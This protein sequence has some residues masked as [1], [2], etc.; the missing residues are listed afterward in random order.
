[1]RQERN[2]SELSEITVVEP[3]PINALA[4][5]MVTEPI[6]HESEVSLNRIR[7]EGDVMVSLGSNDS[8]SSFSSDGSGS[9]QK[10]RTNTTTS[11]ERI[12]LQPK[13]EFFSTLIEIYKKKEQLSRKDSS[14]DKKI[15]NHLYYFL[16][17]AIKKRDLDVE[18]DRRHSKQQMYNSGEL[19]Y[20]SI[21]LNSMKIRTLDEIKV[22]KDSFDAHY[23]N[24]NY[25]I[26]S[27]MEPYN[28]DFFSIGND[29]RKFFINLITEISKKILKRIDKIEKNSC[30]GARNISRIGKN[31]IDG[32]VS[33]L[34]YLF[35]NLTSFE[36]KQLTADSSSLARQ[37]NF[38]P[39]DEAKGVT[40]IDE[41]FGLS[42]DELNNLTNYI[43][44]K[45]GRK[46]VLYKVSD[47]LSK[48][49]VEDLYLINCGTKPKLSAKYKEQIEGLRID[50]TNMNTNVSNNP[51]SS[52][53]FGENEDL[54]PKNNVRPFRQEEFNSVI[55][56]TIQSPPIE[57]AS[58]TTGAE[59]SL[60]N[61]V[62][63]ANLALGLGGQYNSRNSL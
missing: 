35:S 50:M 41:I 10:T 1:M 58:N 19:G 23:I 32:C 56:T 22:E 34:K 59:L 28:A 30:F 60:P 8:I 53:R 40:K 43:S 25:K 17:S 4:G 16:L 15:V 12:K 51:R 39:F 26:L 46:N 44:L 20:F 5:Q 13:K 47:G 57:I 49:I 37:Y 63:T 14:I 29:N 2:D 11:R 9:K 31:N 48:N 62:V 3:M 45:V 33:G 18:I 7:F 61:S 24:P 36:V 6:E 52:T 55:A 38:E 54:S 27:N 21:R 42:E